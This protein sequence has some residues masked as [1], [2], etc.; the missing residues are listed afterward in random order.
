MIIAAK[1]HMEKTGMQEYEVVVMCWTSIMNAVEWN[2][3]EELVADQSLKHL[4]VYAPLLGA[5]CTTGR[6]QLTL[7]VKMQEYC[8]DNMNFMKVFQKIVVLLYKSKNTYISIEAMNLI[9]IH[10]LLSG[11]L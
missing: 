6:S 7:M 11:T 1:E 4:R 2:K 8:Y 3:K 10:N 9:H 5:L